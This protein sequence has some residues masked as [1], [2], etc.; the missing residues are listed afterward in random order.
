MEYYQILSYILINVNTYFLCKGVSSEFGENFIHIVLFMML[1]K[2]ATQLTQWLDWI[3]I[4]MAR[5]LLIL[6]DLN[7]VSRDF[8]SYLIHTT[9]IKQPILWYFQNDLNMA[10]KF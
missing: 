8:F 2:C 7:S 4:Q 9:I 5:L 10:N 6:K 3:N 1:I